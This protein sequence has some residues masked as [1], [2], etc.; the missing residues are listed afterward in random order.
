MQSR[1]LSM[2]TVTKRKEVGGQNE[3]GRTQ[4]SLTIVHRRL[5]GRG[6]GSIEPNVS[7]GER[8]EG[9]AEVGVRE[10]MGGDRHRVG[11]RGF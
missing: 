3:R 2:G 4:D 8:I 10:E 9:H 6:E 1:L 7:E 11:E 5:K